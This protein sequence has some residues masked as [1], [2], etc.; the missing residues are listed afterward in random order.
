MATKRV[1]CPVRT[2]PGRRKTSSLGLRRKLIP[3]CCSRG[4]RRAV[5]PPTHPL[6]Y[7]YIDPCK[8][9]KQKTWI[10]TPTLNH[11]ASQPSLN[12]HCDSHSPTPL[13]P[14]NFLQATP[15]PFPLPVFPIFL[16]FV[17]SIP[18][19]SPNPSSNSVHP[20]LP[21]LRTSLRSAPD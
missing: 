14:K 16:V 4:N 1:T 5:R 18:P 8:S 7:M 13:T 15:R 12:S 9:R 6:T 19:P 21:L 11:H 10:E 17:P 3:S 20:S 2:G